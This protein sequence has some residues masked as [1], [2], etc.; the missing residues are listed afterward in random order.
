MREEARKEKMGRK[1]QAIV[2]YMLDNVQS[3]SPSAA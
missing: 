3:V 2:Q 1:A